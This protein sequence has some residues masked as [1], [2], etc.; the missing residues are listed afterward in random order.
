MGPVQEQPALQLCWN[1]AAWRWQGC[2]SAPSS[3]CRSHPPSVLQCAMPWARPLL[4]LGPSSPPGFSPAGNG[5]ASLLAGHPSGKITKD[6][7]AE[8]WGSGASVYES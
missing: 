7:K 4:G 8:M 6:K 3:L 2:K 1:E 5:S